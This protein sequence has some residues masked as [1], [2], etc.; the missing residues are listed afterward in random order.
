[1]SAAEIVA[2][3]LLAT[4][5]LSLAAYAFIMVGADSDPD[6]GLLKELRNEAERVVRHGD[7]HPW[8]DR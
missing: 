2:W 1:M 8:L 5:V 7:Q 4:I 3:G 6:E